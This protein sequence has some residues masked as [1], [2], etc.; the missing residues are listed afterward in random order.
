M[1]EQK[2]PIMLFDIQDYKIYA[3]PYESYKLDLS[4]KSQKKIEE[5]YQKALCKNQIV[6][7]IRDNEKRKL[8]SYSLDYSR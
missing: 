7:F 8:V 2:K 4:E 5:Q 3:Y 1:Y 6:V